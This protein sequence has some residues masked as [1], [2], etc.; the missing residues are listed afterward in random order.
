MIS[1]KAKYALRALVVLARADAEKALFISD[2]AE[3]QNIPKKFLEQILLDLKHQGIVMSRRGKMGGYL[4]LKPAEDITFGEVLRLIDGPIAP[5]P[6]L[7]KIAYR[8]C[9]DCQSE[10]TCEIRHVF[11][12]VANVTRGVLDKTTIAD[13]LVYGEDGKVA[14]MLDS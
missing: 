3:E 1:Q 14:E 8:R 13:C 5:L 10:E 7:S 4:L 2:I 12:E 11:N 6:C 9:E